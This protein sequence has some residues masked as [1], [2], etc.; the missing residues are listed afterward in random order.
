VQ[1][2]PNQSCRET[3]ETHQGEAAAG[4]CKHKTAHAPRN[5]LPLRTTACA[6]PREDKVS[7]R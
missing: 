6:V 7:S 5:N 2:A 1:S 4:G 3:L